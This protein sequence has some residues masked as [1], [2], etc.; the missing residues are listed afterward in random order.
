MEIQFI[1]P[2]FLVSPGIRIALDLYGLFAI[3]GN[4]DTLTDLKSHIKLKNS[5]W[6]NNVDMRGSRYSPTPKPYKRYTV[7]VVSLCEYPSYHRF[8]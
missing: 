1:T 5:R 7:R 8:H 6:Q 2:Y 3:T 4:L